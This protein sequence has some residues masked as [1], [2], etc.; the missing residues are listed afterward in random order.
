MRWMWRGEGGEEGWGGGCGWGG[1]ERKDEGDV[2]GGRRRGRMR[3]M[4]RGEGERKDEG[5]VE[6]RRRSSRNSMTV[7]CLEDSVLI[8]R[9]LYRRCIYLEGTPLLRDIQI[10]IL[11]HIIVKRNVVRILNETLLWMSD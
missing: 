9:Y 5:D 3:G 2:E 6:E 7:E 11:I 8:C 4:W 1:G 10:L